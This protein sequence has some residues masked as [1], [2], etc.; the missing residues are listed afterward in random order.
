MKTGKNFIVKYTSQCVLVLMIS[1]FLRA[2]QEASVDCLMHYKGKLECRLC[3]PTD[4]PLFVEDFDKDIKTPNPCQPLT[5]KT[6]KAKGITVDVDEPDGTKSKRDFMYTVVPDDSGRKQ[7]HIYENNPDLGGYNEIF[8]DHALFESVY[9][10]IKKREK[11][12]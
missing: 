5:E 6:I 3:A 8:E 12:K 11:L 10:A 2:V 7:V 1:S 9:V 4:E